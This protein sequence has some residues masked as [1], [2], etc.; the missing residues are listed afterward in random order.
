MHRIID[1]NFALHACAIPRQSPGMNVFD[2]PGLTFV[3]SGLSCDTF[4]IIHISDGEKMEK[5]TIEQVLDYYKS[6]L[7]DY[8]IWVNRENLSPAVAET[9]AQC[10]AGRQNEEVGMVL[11]LNAYQLI[12]KPTHGQ[13]K[14][15]D[16]P[17]LIADYAQVLA[18]NWEPP[19]QNVL[20]F[21][22]RTVPTYLDP[23]HDIRLL[24]YY[25][26]DL[27]VASLELFPTDSST[28]GIYGFATLNAYRGRGI[29][30][31]LFTFALNY[32]KT[33]GYQQVIL[34]ASE[35]GLGIYKR[36]GF[37]TVTTYYEYA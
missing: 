22:E 15:A 20:R 16:Q 18:H 35:D 29:G 7:L 2:H 28:I 10:G 30:S 6:R 9:L 17:A 25:H 24:V 34:Q 23:G 32:A 8:C 33:A 36:Y 21:Y 19:D 27:P 37:Q 3:N 26:G 11:D 4:N 14:T 31:S 1:R 13:I 5:N 12:S